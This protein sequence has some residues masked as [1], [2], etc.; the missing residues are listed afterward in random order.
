MR[1][2]LV[3]LPLFILPLSA[4]A[5]QAPKLEVFGGYSNFT[6]NLNV[7]SFNMNGFNISAAENVNSWFGGVLDVSGHFGKENGFQTNMESA[8]YGPV[9]SYRKVHHVVVFGEGLLGAVRGG[10]EYLNI[11][12]PE[13]RF[14]AMAGAGLDVQVTPMVALRLVHADYMMTRFSGAAQD[15]VRISAGIVLRFGKTK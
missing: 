9:F 12:K 4:L 3:L 8:M 1:K 5:Q 6:G 14:G 13:V 10:P 11:S 7:S 2:L 15:N